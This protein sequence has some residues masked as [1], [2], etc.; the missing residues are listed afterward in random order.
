MAKRD[1]RIYTLKEDRYIVNELEAHGDKVD[2]VAIAKHLN[3]S[4]ASVCQRMRILEDRAFTK[5]EITQLM[6]AAKPYVDNDEKVPWTKIANRY[7]WKMNRSPV[8]LRRQY[9][10]EKKRQNYL[11]SDVSST[12]EYETTSET[13]SGTCSE[14]SENVTEDER[15]DRTEDESDTCSGRSRSPSPMSSD[16]YSAEEL[17]KELD[18]VFNIVPPLEPVVKPPEIV[19]TSNFPAYTQQFSFTLRFMPQNEA[20]TVTCRKLNE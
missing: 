1:P 14:R 5:D 17:E 18:Q 13:S 12:D 16:L 3:R 20:F 11:G 7:K 10:K 4:P 19:V 15:E 9:F 2:V 6:D 8:A